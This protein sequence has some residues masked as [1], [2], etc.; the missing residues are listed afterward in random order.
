MYP[1]FDPTF[2]LLI[3]AVILAFYAQSKVKRTFAKYSRVTTAS[4]LTG[5]DVAR[6]IL[7][8][9]RMSDVPVKKTPGTLT[10]HYHPKKREL[11]LSEPVYGS[12]SVAAQGV[13]AHEAGHAIQHQEG[14]APL[15]FRNAFV[16]VANFGSG[17]ALPLFI[18]G[19][20]FSQTMGILMDIGI[21][22]FIAAVVFHLVTLPVEFNASSRAIALLQGRG[23]LQGSE[24]KHAQAVLN[25]AAWT[26]VASATM[27]LMQLVRL[28]ILRSYRD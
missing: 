18:I 17:A 24:V 25:A 3:P 5:A 15:K 1:F 21:L 2:I 12:N 14:Y 9:N 13:A 28:L 27:A 7:D 11:Y 23:Y 16:P 26:Y 19:F 6:G 22:F 10:D 20:I 4:G 8:A